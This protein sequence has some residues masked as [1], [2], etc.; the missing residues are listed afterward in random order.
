M[1]RGQPAKHCYATRSNA[2]AGDAF[3]SPTS[4]MALELVYKSFHEDGIRRASYL[5]D[6]LLKSVSN[7]AFPTG[8]RFGIGHATR[9][10]NVS[11]AMCLATQRGAGISPC[12]IFSL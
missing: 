7:D 3:H 11:R 12:C 2:Q 8:Y 9:P 1:A 4:T 6:Q 5:E 10:P